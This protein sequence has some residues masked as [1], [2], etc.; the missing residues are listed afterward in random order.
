MNSYKFFRLLFSCTKPNF[1]YLKFKIGITDCESYMQGYL[2]KI[3]NLDFKKLGADVAGF[4]L[5][6][7]DIKR[8]ENFR[9]YMAQ[10]DLG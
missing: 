2:E 8:V 5:K 3:E 6:E 7:D 4:L 10:V 9:E 1:K